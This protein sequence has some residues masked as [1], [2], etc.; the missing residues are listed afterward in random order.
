MYR[1][2]YHSVPRFSHVREVARFTFDSCYF[3]ENSNDYS[4]LPVK[5]LGLGTMYLWSVPVY[6]TNRNVFF[7]N[8]GSALVGI[9]TWCIFEDGSVITF[10]K[11]SAKNGGAITLL[12][13]SYLVL[14]G[15]TTLNF[16]HNIAASVSKLSARL[17]LSRSAV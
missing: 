9:S 7:G 4:Q 14:F 1:S 2:V 17:Y 10:V 6:F 15:N 5:P 8:N 11:N 12:D 16:S 3:I 13:N